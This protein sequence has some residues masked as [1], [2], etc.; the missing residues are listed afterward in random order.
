MRLWQIK[1]LERS[2]AR[3]TFD[4][5]VLLL[6]DWLK[7]RAGQSDR[8]DLSR[9]YVATQADSNVVLGYYAIATHRVVYD[10]LPGEQSK[11]LPRIDI[12]VVLLARLAVDR[13]IQGQGLGSL[14][15]IDALRR[16]MSIADQI[17]IRAVEVDAFDDQAKR[18]YLK[19]GFREL[20]DDPQHLFLPMHEIRKLNFDPF[21]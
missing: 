4:C 13:S 14:L 2:H 3:A 15:L 9:T 6:D 11:G 12:P 18:F 7:Q 16:S 21:P 1:R 8:K 5:G 19:Y 10:Q 20:L 17:G